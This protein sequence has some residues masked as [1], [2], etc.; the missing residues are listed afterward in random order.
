[1]R[2][3]RYARKDVIGLGKSSDEI[4][5]SP[6]KGASRNDVMTNDGMTK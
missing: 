6:A 4:A 1:M 5:A 2:L 3:L